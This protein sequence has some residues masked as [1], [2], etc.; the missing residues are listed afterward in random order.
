M[1][2][3]NIESLND[4]GTIVSVTKKNG[5]TKTMLYDP[6]HMEYL[7]SLFAST[8]RPNLEHVLLLAKPDLITCQDSL[9]LT[10][11]LCCLCAVDNNV[12]SNFKKEIVCISY[13]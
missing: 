4:S 6:L 2:K 1:Q 10:L 9:H 5:L 13:V 7:F 12:Y 11:W 8:V 3:M